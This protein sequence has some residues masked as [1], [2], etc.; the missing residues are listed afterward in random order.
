MYPGLLFPRAN[1]PQNPATFFCLGQHYGAVFLAFPSPFGLDSQTF[2]LSTLCNISDRSCITRF[3]YTLQL[4]THLRL[5]IFVAATYGRQN[6]EFMFG[7]ETP[8]IDGVRLG[9]Q[10][11]IGSAGIALRIGI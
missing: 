9:R 3:D 11:A 5:E 7:I 6:G 10:P 4:L 8:G 2:V 1:R